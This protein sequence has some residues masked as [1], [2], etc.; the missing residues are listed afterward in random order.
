MHRSLLDTQEVRGSSPLSP[1]RARLRTSVPTSQSKN[2]RRYQP[3]S[4]CSFRSAVIGAPAPQ[5]A[6]S[7]P[8]SVLLLARLSN[9]FSPRCYVAMITRQRGHWGWR[10][11]LYTGKLAPT[12]SLRRLSLQC[13]ARAWQWLEEIRSTTTVGFRSNHPQWKS[14]ICNFGRRFSLTGTLSA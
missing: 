7:E 5:P 3:I 10:R 11:P 1:I 14:R 8:G 6:V 12:D 4:A 2:P 13:Y 9:R